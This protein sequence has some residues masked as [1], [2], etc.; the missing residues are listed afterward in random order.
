MFLPLAIKL[1]KCNNVT[2]LRSP[3]FIQKKLLN[4]FLPK[5]WLFYQN[6]NKGRYYHIQITINVVISY[7]E[8][9]N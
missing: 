9:N 3:F 6:Y 4:Y 8:L 1:S 2:E 5:I 7:I